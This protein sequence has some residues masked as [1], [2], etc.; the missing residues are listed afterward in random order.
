MVTIW[1]KKTFSFFLFFALTDCFIPAGTPWCSIAG[2][3][4]LP[5]E[6]MSTSPTEQHGGKVFWWFSR[7]QCQHWD[8]LQ[9]VTLYCYESFASTLS[10]IRNWILLLAKLIINV[11]TWQCACTHTCTLTF[12]SMYT[13]MHTR[14]CTC[15]YT[16]THLEWRADA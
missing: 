9:T 11:V 16:H 5:Q 7:N 6:F 4:Q 10:L 2:S 13:H 14:V 3:G 8:F 15:T 1:R 12:I